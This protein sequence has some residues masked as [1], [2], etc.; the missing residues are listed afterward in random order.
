LPL[1]LRPTQLRDAVA[2]LAAKPLSVLAGGTDFYP[3]RVGRPLTED[4]LD[5]TAIGELGAIEDQGSHWRIGAAASWRSIAE[6][7][8]PAW[9]DALLL[10]GREVGGAQIQNAGTL[11]GNLCNASPAA[12]G[13]PALLALD[14]TVELAS[15]RGRRTLPLGAFATGPRRTA[16]ASDEL[17]TA[18][19]LP[20]PASPRAAS[21]FLKLGS[22]RYLV[23]S[24]AM[25]A[26][27]LEVDAQGRIEAAR[28]AV[29]A[30]SP[31][32][33]RLPGLEADLLGR[34]VDDSP[35]ACATIAHLEPLAPIDDVRADA[36][37]RRTAALVLVR[38]A[39]D[40]A[41]AKA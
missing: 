29:G 41:G 3:A 9:C 26:V 31:V 21:H 2:T 10:A 35:G 30:C 11:G 33:V 1:Y 24:F 27:A 36:G 17:L 8:L 28:V 34:R 25:V 23:I 40:L 12:D 5:V 13:V 7:G 14:A 39:I 37:Y 19:S 32:A 20:K 18:V 6:A 38:R 4:V 15:V 22:R 16:R